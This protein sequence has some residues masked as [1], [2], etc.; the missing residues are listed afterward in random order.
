MSFIDTFPMQ[1]NNIL[2][3]YSE[4]D[5]IKLDPVYQREGDIWPKEKKQ[6]LIDSIINNY[7]IPKLYFHKLNKKQKGNERHEYAVIDGRQRIETI[8]QFIDGDF[9]L[10]NYFKYIKDESVNISG[11]TYND[12]AR[13]HPKIK[14]KFDS[15][16]LPIICVETDD[17][18][19]IDEMFSRLNEAV[20]LNAAEKRNAIGGDFA[21]A[22]RN[23]S[24]HNFFKNNVKFKNTRYQYREVSARLLWLECS[25]FSKN[26]IVDTKKVYL[27]LVTHAL[28]KGKKKLVN[29]L[30]G[31]VTNVLDLMASTFTKN[32]QLLQAQA[33]I[34]IYYLLFRES[35]N[36][37][38]SISIE[39]NKIELFKKDL[40]ENRKKAEIDLSQANYSYLEFDRLS[41]QG[42]ND[43]SSIKERLSIIKEY[44]DFPV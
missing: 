22:I 28:K 41:Q 20:P 31:K 17:L 4:R 19:L 21:A 24:N 5:E 36:C 9:S 11:F 16:N 7:D 38:K 2:R 23:I 1:H 44:F 33:A 30:V 27:D 8:W 10:D 26:R 3:I 43:A 42:T 13:K 39:R 32:D 35:I 40:A 6:L 14:S 29:E 34:T 12:L 18:D 25:L 15:F 37:D